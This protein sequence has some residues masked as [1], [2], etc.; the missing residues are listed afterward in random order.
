MCVGKRLQAL[1]DW[2]FFWGGLTS[3]SKFKHRT[4]QII[5]GTLRAEETKSPRSL[6]QIPNNKKYVLCLMS[7]LKVIISICL[8]LAIPY[9]DIYCVLCIVFWN[10]SWET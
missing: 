3:D 1:D 4:D 6:P 9:L 2:G 8:G 10:K 5:L 7:V